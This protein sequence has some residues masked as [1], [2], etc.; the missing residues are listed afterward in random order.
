MQ[1][2][3]DA[4]LTELLARL[5]EIY[6]PIVGH[7]EVRYKRPCADRWDVVRPIALALQEDLRRPLRAL[8]IGCAQGFFALSLASLGIEVTGIDRDPSNIAVCNFLREENPEFQLA[9]HADTL[10]ASLANVADGQFDLIL[11]L[12][13][14]HHVAYERGLRFAQDVVT[15]LVRGASVVIVELATKEEALYWS[16]ALPSEPSVLLDE[17]P[18]YRSLGR[19]A[20]HLGEVQ[21]PM[22][23]VSN[24]YAWVERCLLRFSDW[25]RDPHEFAAG[26]HQGTRR[27]FFGADVFVKWY[28]LAG[29]RAD[30][31]RREYFAE[32][33]FL[34]TVG[35]KWPAA[36]ALRASESDDDFALVAMERKPG[37]RLSTL[38]VESVEYDARELIRQML[39]QLAELEALGLY[40]DDVRTWNILVDDGRATLIDYGAIGKI[41]ADCAWP[42]NVFVSFLLFAN[43]VAS[44]QA[45]PIDPVRP[46]LLHPIN[47]HESIAGWCADVWA[48]PTKDWSFRLFREKFEARYAGHE[49]HDAR[50]LVPRQVT[51]DWWIAAAERHSGILGDALRHLEWRVNEVEAHLTRRLAAREAA[52]EA[53]RTELDRVGHE[54]VATRAEQERVAAE[55]AAMRAE[56]ERVAAVAERELAIV[57]SER[58]ARIAAMSAELAA[59]YGSRSWR[60]TA[61]LRAVFGAARSARRKLRDAR[62]A[63]LRGARQFV[64]A[65]P[66]PRNMAKRFLAHHP[67][68]NRRLRAMV[69]E[70]HPAM[71][72]PIIGDPDERSRS[73]DLEMGPRAARVLADLELERRAAGERGSDVPI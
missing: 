38:I 18:F 35:K 57:R 23:F 51:L 25:A 37:V 44:R 64:V 7:P 13:V 60:L 32:Q 69:G 70:W 42:D 9:F 62:S 5:P 53:S 72:D 14:L 46:L 2:H 48:T 36:P 29:S 67:E 45:F 47:A 3:R 19:H 21:R 15:Q 31:N 41:P 6:Q 34:S 17:Q 58:D 10:D 55:A 54:L 71:G 68:L 43:E 26:T 28:R 22:F 49:S 12:S 39:V 73:N 4:P 52:M 50:V 8:D 56:L 30:I 40:H 20:T 65:R 66:V 63:V 11:G 24:R 61:P 27:Y 1:N 59:A 16:E 33:E